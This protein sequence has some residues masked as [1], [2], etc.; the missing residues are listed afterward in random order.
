MSTA[1]TLSY[2]RFKNTVLQITVLCGMA[3]AHF[4]DMQMNLFGSKH[5]ARV[6]FGFSPHMHYLFG[7]CAIFGQE[8]E[9]LYS[10]NCW[11]K[12]I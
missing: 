9:Q 7:A 5:R 12:V 3:N 11:I 6:T 4:C 1:L 10:Q 8:P 2:A